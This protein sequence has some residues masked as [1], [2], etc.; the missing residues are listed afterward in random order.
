MTATVGVLLALVFLSVLFSL[1]SH[2][3]LELIRMM[4]LQ[5]IFVS[6]VPFLMETH[7]GFALLNFVLLAVMVF[8]QGCSHSRPAVAGNAQDPDTPGD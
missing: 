1:S 2:R 4:A 8:Y 6:L 7:E 5:G 3:L